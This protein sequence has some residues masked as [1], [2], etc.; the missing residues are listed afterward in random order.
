MASEVRGL[1]NDSAPCR[2]RLFSLIPIS[3]AVHFGCETFK[4]SG[5]CC[6]CDNSAPSS[7]VTKFL[8]LYSHGWL[9]APMLKKGS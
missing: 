9:L 8:E 1:K 7:L 2:L 3:E 6:L 5:D 4:D